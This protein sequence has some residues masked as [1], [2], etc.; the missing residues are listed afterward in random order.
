NS[1][2][3]AAYGTR[4]ILEADLI[5][6]V[7]DEGINDADNLQMA[8]R[9]LSEVIAF[10]ELADTTLATNPPIDSGALVSSNVGAR[11]GILGEARK[12]E[13]SEEFINAFGKMQ[14]VLKEKKEL[15]RVPAD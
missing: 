5:V 4:P 14:M 13:S 8:A 11:L 10:I 12:F 6:R 7:K 2:V 15:S 3:S 1:K 9:H